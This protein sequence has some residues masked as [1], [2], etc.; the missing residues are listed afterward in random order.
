M[1]PI[2]WTD[3]KDAFKH[4]NYQNVNVRNIQF[5]TDSLP[6]IRTCLTFDDNKQLEMFL[7][8]EHKLAI[9]TQKFDWAAFI[10]EKQ[11][12][13]KPD[14]KSFDRVYLKYL[15]QDKSSSVCDLLFE[16][17]VLSFR[18]RLIEEF[19]SY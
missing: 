5:E 12:N 8:K 11:K 2:A 18:Y 6:E 14:D 3:L 16:T 9:E 15:I 4:E 1:N 7:N 19:N 10:H 17:N 13:L